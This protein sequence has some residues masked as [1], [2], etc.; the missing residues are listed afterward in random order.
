MLIKT[1]R[2]FTILR[3][4]VFSIVNE[5]SQIECEKR[6][7]EQIFRH[8]VSAVARFI[9]VEMKSE[10]NRVNTNILYFTRFTL[11]PSTQ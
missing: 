9:I 3:V 1:T 7:L 10:G 11:L 2:L 4:S 8:S 5:S 6:P